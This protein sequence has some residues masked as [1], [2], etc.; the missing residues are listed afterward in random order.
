VELAADGGA[1]IL[2]RSDGVLNVR[3]VRIGPG[4]IY[5]VLEAFPEVA[6]AA[7][8]EQRAP[9]EP[10]GSRLALFVVMKEKGTLQRPLVLKIKKELAVRASPAHVPGVIVEVSDLPRTHNGKLSERAVRDAANGLPVKNATALKNPESL[11]EIGRH[12]GAS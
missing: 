7:A 1:R 5:R 12:A 6:A 3:G 4:E 8:V 2:G 11:E 9:D 10:G